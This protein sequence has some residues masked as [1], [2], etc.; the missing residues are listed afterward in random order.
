MKNKVLIMGL[1]GV[2]WKLLKPWINDGK[3]PTLSKLLKEG[4]ESDLRTT[5][6]PISCSAWTSLFTGKNPGKHGIYEYTSDLGELVNAKSIKVEK[7]WQVLSYYNKRCCVINVPATYPVEKLN[8][9]MVSSILTPPQEE[10]Y[11]YPPELMS[12]LKK[13]D[14]QIRVNYQNQIKLPNEQYILHQ[15]I[16]ILNRIYSLLKNR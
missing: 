13:H 7:I 2:S 8:G 1:D 6:P 4:A 16:I 5:V 3:L 14:Y 15:R 9:Y 11:S 10:I 12:I